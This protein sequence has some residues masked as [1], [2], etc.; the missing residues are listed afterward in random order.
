MVVSEFSGFAVTHVS[1]GVIPTPRITWFAFMFCYLIWLDWQNLPRDVCCSTRCWTLYVVDVVLPWYF[2][3]V[4]LDVLLYD[5]SCSY[6]DWYH[7]YPLSPFSLSLTL[8]I[9][10]FADLLCGLLLDIDLVLLHQWACTC[11]S[12][13]PACLCLACHRGHGHLLWSRIPTG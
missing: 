6:Y 1:L 11:L 5:S 3:E 2:S 4:L 9:H 13:F 8:E 10:I 12:L 7:L